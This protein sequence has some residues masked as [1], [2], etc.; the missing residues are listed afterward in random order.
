MLCHL[1]YMCNYT[2]HNYF[3]LIVS[4]DNLHKKYLYFKYH[5]P[6][7]QFNLLNISKLQIA[8]FYHTYFKNHKLLNMMASNKMLIKERT[9]SH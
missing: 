1:R 6:N 4:F 8:C 7:R 3:C 5:V 2:L 9:F